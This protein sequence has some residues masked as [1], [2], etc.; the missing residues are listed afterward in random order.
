MKVKKIVI[1]L[2][3][4]L[5]LGCFTFS[6]C[7]MLP[8]EEQTLAPP[9]VK[10]KKQQYELYEIKKKDITKEIKGNGSLI[11]MNETNVFTKEN[12]RRIKEV[13]V[14]YGQTVKKGEVLIVLDSDNMEN[15]VKI[16]QYNLQKAQINYA[17]AAEGN[18][19]YNK[20]LANIDVQMEKAKLENLQKLLAYSKL[21][22]P[23]DGKVVFLESVKQGDTIEPF[24]VLATVADPNNLQVMYQSSD[25]DKV[26]SGMKANLSLNGKK[27]DGVVAQVPTIGKY[28]G[29]IIINFKNSF[30]DA[31]LGDAIEL[32]I[33]LETKKDT[34]VIPKEAVKSFMG[35][36]TVE[37]LDGD[38]KIST[39]VEKGIETS[40]EIEILT[41]LKEGQKV[42][43]N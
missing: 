32:S 22:A 4:I 8:K 41:G 5:I 38:K 19:E 27:Y 13:K 10:P 11:S 43:L 42:I 28:K 17:R 40:T 18:D 26:Q 7:G 2:L 9:L 16:Q 20:Q 33:T 29:S 14:Q 35:N 39:S 31:E 37:V 3:S 15:D 36:N 1:S 30:K 34:I 21:T 12:N 25:S 6:G 23:T 24:K